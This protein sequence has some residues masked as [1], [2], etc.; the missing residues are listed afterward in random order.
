ML[1]LEIG[2]LGLEKTIGS[3]TTLSSLQVQDLQVDVGVL[4]R[5]VG[6]F[7]GCQ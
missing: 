3:S 1:S 2:R 5:D 4:D 6:A 7:H